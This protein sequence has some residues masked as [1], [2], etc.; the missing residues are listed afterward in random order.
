M[1]RYNKQVH[2]VGNKKPTIYLFLWNALHVSGGPSAHHQELKILYTASGT[3]SNLYCYLP[4]SLQ[5]AVTVWQSTRCY[6][7]SFWAHDDGRRNRLKHVEYFTEINKLCN[8]AFVGYT[9]KYVGSEFF[10]VINYLP[11]KMCFICCHIFV[12]A[13]K[14]SGF[15][16]NASG[17]LMQL[18]TN[19]VL[20]CV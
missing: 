1:K 6:I 16:M 7:Y 9:W 12:C 2:W 15:V 5:V 19:T 4:L 8:V 10:G 20:L 17:L 18:M 3:L 14:M 11:M 13:V